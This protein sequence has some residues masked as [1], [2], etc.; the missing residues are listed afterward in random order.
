MKKHSYQKHELLCAIATSY[1]M[2]NG[3]LDRLE[4]LIRSVVVATVRPQPGQALLRYLGKVLEKVAPPVMVSA[5]CQY[6]FAASVACEFPW[7]Q[8]TVGAPMG[9]HAGDQGLSSIPEMAAP[10]EEFPLDRK[11]GGWGKRTR[12]YGGSAR[13]VADTPTRKAGAHNV[14]CCRDRHFDSRDQ[15]H[16][17]ADMGGAECAVAGAA[18]TEDSTGSTAA[19]VNAGAAVQG[20]QHADRPVGT[21]ISVDSKPR[22]VAKK[23]RNG[24]AG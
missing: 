8:G 1:I 6:I 22:R 3:R 9:Y 14:A 18:S 4:E 2:Y 11:P 16:V 5:A 24:T 21:G 10:L 20:A 7:R 15:L 12:R 17:A 19:A 23:H 13:P